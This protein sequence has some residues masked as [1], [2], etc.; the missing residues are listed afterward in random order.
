MTFAAATALLLGAC[1]PKHPT[2]TPPPGTATLVQLD[3]GG[4][5][6][7]EKEAILRALQ[8]T[9]ARPCFETLLA[10]NPLA[11]GEV[12]V[13]F[14]VGPGAAVTEAA[15]AFSTLGDAA[16]DQCVADAVRAVPFPN[17]DTAI[18]VLYPFLL[19]TE[20]TPAE[21]ARALRD[22]YGLLPENEKDPGSEPGSPIPPGLVVVW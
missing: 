20:R 2:A 15:P 7:V 5:R 21:V 12:V 1:A 13:R 4:A 11:Y 6:S 18:T 16:A 9:A 3:T 19:L 8:A 14:T 22:R 17:R 10:A